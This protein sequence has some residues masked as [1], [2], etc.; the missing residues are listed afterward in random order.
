[1]ALC[2][3]ASGTPCAAA[4]ALRLSPSRTTCVVA[5]GVPDRM[6][7]TSVCDGVTPAWITAP[8]C[9]SSL[10]ASAGEESTIATSASGGGGGIASPG[11]AGTAPHPV[12]T[13]PHTTDATLIAPA[14][15]AAVT[16]AMQCS[17]TRVRCRASTQSAVRLNKSRALGPPVVFSVWSTASYNR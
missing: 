14:R 2:S 16:M 3:A 4:M 13:S 10:A 8:S 7:T 15:G 6:V 1:L 9:R 11:G 12:I 5:A 17:K